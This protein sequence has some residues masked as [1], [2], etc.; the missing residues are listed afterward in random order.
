MSQQIT[1]E[2]HLFHTTLYKQINKKC[3]DVIFKDD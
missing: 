2:K 3:T 1:P